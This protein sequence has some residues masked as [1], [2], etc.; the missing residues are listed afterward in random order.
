MLQQKKGWGK[1]V[2]E[3][4][5][6][7]D[8]LTP[9]LYSGKKKKKE[10]I[11]VQINSKT[12]RDQWTWDCKVIIVFLHKFSFFW[13]FFANTS[14]RVDSLSFLPVCSHSALSLLGFT[15]VYLVCG[16]EGDFILFYYIFLFIYFSHCTARGSGYPYMYTLQLHFFPHPFFCCNMSI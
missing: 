1:T 5:T 6:C 15:L 8:N 16:L 7:K 4:Y 14:Y 10:A 12:H 13:I 2:T 11:L 3:M 9:L